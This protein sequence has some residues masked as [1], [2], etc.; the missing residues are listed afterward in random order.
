MKLT[1]YIKDPEWAVADEIFNAKFESM[2]DVIDLIRKI[3]KEKVEFDNAIYQFN[4]TVHNTKVCLSLIAR[5]EEDLKKRKAFKESHIGK[6]IQTFIENNT[7]ENL[8]TIKREIESSN[9]FSVYIVPEWKP[10]QGERMYGVPQEAYFH[11]GYTNTFYPFD[12]WDIDED[13]E[14]TEM[15]IKNAK[16]DL[17]K[18]LAV[19]DELYEKY[20]MVSFAILFDRFEKENGPLEADSKWANWSMFV[21]DDDYDDDEDY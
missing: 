14:S 9:E 2:P 5:A 6:L 10:G 4:R 20:D 1:K 19:K 21:D 16:D 18:C 12:N 11:V 13:I 17:N 8:N 3:D 15:E 7:N